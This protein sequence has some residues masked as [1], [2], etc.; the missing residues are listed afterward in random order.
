VAKPD[1]SGEARHIVDIIGAGMAPSK[2]PGL[3][4]G[5]REGTS[6]ES[7]KG[8][9]CCMQVKFARRLPMAEL[10]GILPVPQP[11]ATRA[12]RPQVK[13]EKAAAKR[14]LGEAP[15]RSCMLIRWFDPV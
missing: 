11:R 5:G 1:T 8:E 15:I 13:G 3:D 6:L 2:P 4:G 12:S 9:T 10:R 7:L 14:T